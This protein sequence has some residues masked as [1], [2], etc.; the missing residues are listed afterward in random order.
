MDDSQVAAHRPSVWQVIKKRWRGW[1]RAVHRDF[2]YLAVGFTIIYAVS[3]IAINHLSDWDPN[4]KTYEKT[5]QI[6]PIP[7]ELSDDDAVAAARAALQLGPPRDV[8]RAGDELHLSYDHRK[9]VIYGD[10]GEVVDQ[11]ASPRFFLRVANWLHYNRGKQAWTYM[12]DIYAVM[13]LYLAISGLFMIKGRLGLKWRGTVLVLLGFAVP[14]TYVTLSGGPEAK[15]G[16]AVAP[17]PTP[18]P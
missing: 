12:A 10:S 11:G 2:G 14:I 3:G 6:A 13:L 15:N 1:L 17:A 18:P 7:A 4:F 5:S 8:Y 16:T 9:V